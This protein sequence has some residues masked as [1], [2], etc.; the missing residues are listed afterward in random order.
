MQQITCANALLLD[1][2]VGPLL[3]KP[4]HVEAERFRG[5]E[6]YHEL[7]FGG[8]LHRKVSRVLS[9]EDA[10]DIGRRKLEMIALLTSVG[11]QTA[12]LSEEMPRTDGW[13]TVASSQ[14]D[15]FHPMDV[16]EAVRQHD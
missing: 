10:I 13:Q 6:I 1:H 5:L 14:R 15:G 7:K 11:Q 16:H 2:L 8:R 9:L 12:E 3:E 4:R